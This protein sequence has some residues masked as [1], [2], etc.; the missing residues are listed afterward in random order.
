MDARTDIEERLPSRGV[1]E[2]PQRAPHRSC[3]SAMAA[4]GKTKN[5]ALRLPATARECGIPF[6]LFDAV[7]IFKKPPSAAGLKPAGRYLAKD[8]FEIGGMPL[9][10]TI[11]LNTSQLHGDCFIE[12]GADVGTL[13]V[14]LTGAEPTEHKTKSKPRETNDRSGALWRYAQQMGPAVDGAVSHPGGAHEKQRH[15][16]I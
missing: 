2:G 5:V 3:L 1:T 12:I 4:A 7:E 9:P 13:N 15:V 11:L 8:I 14:K 6:D 10:M 16:G